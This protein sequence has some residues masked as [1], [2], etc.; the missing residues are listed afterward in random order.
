LQLDG[1]AL[2]SLAL[3][4]FQEL[5]NLNESDRDK[6]E[7]AIADALGTMYAGQYLLSHSDLVERIA[8]F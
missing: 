7:E 3:E 1:T 6:A 5:E 4:N 8:V 2:P